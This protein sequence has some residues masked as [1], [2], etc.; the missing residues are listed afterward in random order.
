MS[1]PQVSLKAILVIIAV[2]AVPLGM[3]ASGPHYLAPLGV[4]LALPVL[5][6]SIFY[7]ISG[8]RGVPIGV[9]LASLSY[10]LLGLLY[11]L[12]GGVGP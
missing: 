9:L 2:L 4:L 12:L 3:I 1:R 8:W 10:C 5:F 6:G 7:V 11:Y